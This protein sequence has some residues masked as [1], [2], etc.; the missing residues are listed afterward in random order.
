VP[1]PCQVVWHV[2]CGQDRAAAGIASRT[3]SCQ[4]IWPGGLWRCRIA[5]SAVFVAQET[6]SKEPHGRRTAPSES[7]RFPDRRLFARGKEPQSRLRSA[8]PASFGEY[9]PRSHIRRA[10]IWFAPLADNSDHA[11]GQGDSHGDLLRSYPPGRDRCERPWAVDWAM[12][13]G[14]PPFP[15]DG[16]PVHAISSADRRARRTVD[17]SPALHR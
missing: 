17:G 15:R 16:G 8:P 3:E 1:V 4:V 13:R 5:F 12:R 11:R 7:G 6:K 2:P 14:R 10:G 9:R